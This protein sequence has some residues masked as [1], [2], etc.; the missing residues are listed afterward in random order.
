MNIPTARDDFERVLS[1]HLWTLIPQVYRDRDGLGDT[2]GALRA[3]VEVIAGQAAQLRRSH[4]RLWDDQQIELCADWA[5]PYIGALLGTRTLPAMSQRGRRIDVAKSIY[6]RRRK[7]TPAVLEQLASDITGWDAALVEGFKR[8]ARLPHPLDAPRDAMEWAAVAPMASPLQMERV[9]G[10]FDRLQHMPDIAAGGCHGINRMAVHLYRLR[11]VPLQG[12]VPLPQGTVADAYTFDP[13]GRDVPLFARRGRTGGEGDALDPDG[14]RP[15]RAW[16][17]PAPI[18]CRLL[19][20]EVFVLTPAVQTALRDF[21]LTDAQVDELRPLLGRVFAGLTRLRTAL[22]TRP[23]S[24]VFLGAATLREIRRLALID[25]CGKAQMLPRSIRVELDGAAAVPLTDMAAGSLADWDDPRA[26]VPL[27][28]DPERGRF[29][30][31]GGTPDGV[32]TTDHHIGQAA[33]IGA[34]SLRHPQQLPTPDRQ[35][36]DGEPITAPN[37]PLNGTLRLSGNATWGQ[38]NNRNGVVDLAIHADAGTR[39]YLRLTG[40]WRLNA[41]EDGNASLHLDGLW[42]GAEAGG[43]AALVLDGDW[44]HVRLTNVTLDPGGALTEDAGSPVLPAIDLVVRGRVELLEIDSCILGRVRTIGGQIDEIRAADSIFD[45]RLALA[46]LDDTDIHLD[47]CTVN[48]AVQG[49]RAW[50]SNTLIRRWLSPVDRQAGCFRFSAAR[51]DSSPPQSYRAHL[52]AGN[53][54]LFLSTRFG[55]PDYMRLRRHGPDAVLTGGENGQEMGAFHALAD[56]ARLAALKTKISEY[57]PLGVL[58]IYRFE[59]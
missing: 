31:P 10:P 41:T 51:E 19:G 36:T 6:Y 4:D 30:F 40:N 20:E 59:T 18:P 24:G 17:V 39:P 47:R 45:D 15:A 55:N 8:L 34:T 32:L 54:G 2:P 16:D 26:T 49:R 56:N 35:R 38:P 42:I 43:A 5:V 13:S 57:A 52:L 28:I 27:V 22:L 33:P 3:L 9:G 14:W 48:G 21:G 44:E 58:P 25:D 50:I 37:L 29:R 23:S 53:T 12:V 11:A 46:P 1:E 7:G